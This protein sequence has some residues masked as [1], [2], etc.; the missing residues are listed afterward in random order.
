[1]S[2][3]SSR[4]VPSVLAAVVAACA[5][6]T[7]GSFVWV[8][9]Y[10]A[11]ASPPVRDAVVH[12]GDSIDVRVLGQ[13]Q[14]SAKVRVR[15]DGHATLPFVGDIAA[16]GRT[17][18]ALVEQIQQRLKEYV[19]S[20]I[21]AVNLEEAPPGPI[22]VM[23]EV[24]RPGQQSFSASLGVLDAI[25]QAGGLTPYAHKDRVFV[26]RNEPNAIRIRFDLNR[27]LHTVGKGNSFLL[28]PGDVVVVE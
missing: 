23:G 7:A 26:L 12:A 19:N 21:V 18:S 3:R 8:D 15:T 14:F 17:P 27:L 13:D 22:S 11:K 28:E 5:S 6:S 1:M 2:V 24:A 16:A 9:E 10:I 4:F 20:P 25:A